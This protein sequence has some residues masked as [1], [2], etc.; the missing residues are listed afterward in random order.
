VLTKSVTNDESKAFLEAFFD[1]FMARGEPV[2][3]ELHPLN[4][5]RDMAKKSPKRAMKRLRMAVGDCLEMS[6]PRTSLQVSEADNI[7]RAE[8]S[9]TL[10]ELRRRFQG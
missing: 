9:I 2:P 5:L 7:L 10:S 3:A 1:R 4:V 6:R 8:G